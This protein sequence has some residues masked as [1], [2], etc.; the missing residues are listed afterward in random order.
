MVI[1]ASS[2]DSRPT[3]CKLQRS[4]TPE[5]NLIVRSISAHLVR[6]SPLGDQ[7]GIGISCANWSTGMPHAAW[8]ILVP[9]K[10]TRTCAQTDTPRGYFNQIVLPKIALYGRGYSLFPDIQHFLPDAVFYPPL[11][12]P[13][14]QSHKQKR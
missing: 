1:P 3:T 13:F 12:L 4:L 2:G 6:W 14:W 10:K 8:H 11:L 7:Y 5:I 9:S